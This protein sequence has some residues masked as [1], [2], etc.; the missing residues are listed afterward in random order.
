M[1]QREL[2]YV[3]VQGK[4]VA[5]EKSTGRQVWATPLKSS[6]FVNLILDG[7][8]LFA[9]TQGELFALDAVTGQLLW[10]DGLKGFGYN[11]ASLVTVSSPQQV[12]AVLR[13]YI[14]QQERSSDSSSSA[15]D[16]SSH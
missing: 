13:E 14:Q 9:H 8:K 16:S 15:G 1:T 3:G 5:Y 4:V 11:L 7:D 10:Q 2:L 12:Q 6:A